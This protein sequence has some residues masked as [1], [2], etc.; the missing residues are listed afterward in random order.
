[1]KFTIS[2]TSDFWFLRVPHRKH[3]LIGPFSS[4]AAAVSELGPTAVYLPHVRGFW[5]APGDPMK[6]L[7]RTYERYKA[8]CAILSQRALSFIEWRERWM[9][10]QKDMT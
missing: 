4:F 10:L 2:K 7:Y 6:A 9:A 5:A 3:V 8:F 1:M